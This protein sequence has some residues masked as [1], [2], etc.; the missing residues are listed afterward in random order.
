MKTK[1]IIFILHFHISYYTFILHFHQNTLSYSGNFREYLIE[2]LQGIDAE[3]DDRFDTLTNKSVKYL[4]LRYKDLPAVSIRHSKISKDRVTLEEIQNR[5]WQYL[6][7][8]LMEKV[9]IGDENFRI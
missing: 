2:F 5:N 1:K 6:I 8:S 9:E 7:E 4:F 3:T